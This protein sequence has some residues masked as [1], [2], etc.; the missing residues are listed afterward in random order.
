M[1][2]K[3]VGDVSIRFSYLTFY[4]IWLNPLKVNTDI[5]KSKVHVVA[6]SGSLG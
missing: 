4:T 1:I 5:S 3:K 6:F 2:I